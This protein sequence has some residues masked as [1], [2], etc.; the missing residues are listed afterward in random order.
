MAIVF[1]KKR[2]GFDVFKSNVCHRVKDIGDFKFIIETLESDLIRKY[3]NMKWYL[4]A[5]YLLAMIDY[6][7]RENDLPLCTNY[8]D[9]RTCKLS[10]LVYPSGISILSIATGDSR[11][12]EESIREAIPEFLQFNIVES[13]VRNVY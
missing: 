12:K 11:Y 6:L 1:A 3:F 7:S 5:L 13:E 8:N 9:I 2:S 10:S 4:E